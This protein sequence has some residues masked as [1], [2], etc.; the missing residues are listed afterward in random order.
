MIRALSILLAALFTAAPVD[1]VFAAGADQGNQAYR[2][3]VDKDLLAYGKIKK[4]A[5]KEV[6]GRVVN[7]S[8]NADPKEGPPRYTLRLIR[9][10]GAVVDVVL[11]AR[12]GEILSVK[13]KD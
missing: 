11:H 6:G 3:R 8:L 4:I 10:D 13:G 2:D 7:Q 9:P 12:T 5:E 1:A